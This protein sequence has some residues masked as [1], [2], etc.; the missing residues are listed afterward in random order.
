VLNLQ[1]EL[2]A[3]LA[4]Q[5]Q[6]SFVAQAQRTQPQLYQQPRKAQLESLTAFVVCLDLNAHG[7][8]V[9]P[10]GIKVSRRPCRQPLIRYVPDACQRQIMLMYD[11]APAA[12]ECWVPPR[13][14]GTSGRSQGALCCK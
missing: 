13:R 11:H 4:T 5:A 6:A 2:G 10:G 8:G 14:T 7:D 1:E 9:L 12:P 3:K